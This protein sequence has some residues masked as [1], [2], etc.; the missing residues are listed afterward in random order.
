M[1]RGVLV[2]AVCVLGCSGARERQPAAKS[3]VTS[4]QIAA[5][6][7]A[8][9]PLRRTFDVPGAAVALVDHGVTVFAKGYGLRD[10]EAGNPVTPNTVFRIGSLTKS[11]TSALVATLVDDGALGFDTRATDIDPS[12]KLPTGDLTDNVT[13]L[14]LLGMGTGLSEPSGFWWDYP[15][16]DDLL[17]SIATTMVVGPEG[18]FLY[19]N[20]VYASGGYVALESVASRDDLAS[21]YAS[22]LDERLFQPLGMSPVAL[23][24]DPSTLGDDVALSYEPSLVAGPDAP[25]E[26][27]GFTPLASVAPAGAIATNVTSLARYAALQL[28]HGLAGT[29]RV[30]SAENLEVTHT[31]QTPIPEGKDAPWLSAYA[32]GWIVGNEGGVPLLWHDGGVDAYRATLRLLPDDELALVTLTNGSNGE[33]LGV[34]LEEKLMQLVYGQADL[35]PEHYTSEYAVTREQLAEVA[36]ALALEAP[37]DA[38]AVAPFLGDYGHEISVELDDTTDELFVVA[39]GSRSRVVRADDLFTAGA[40]LLASG[41]FAGN[42]LTFKQVGARTEFTVLDPVSHDPLLILAR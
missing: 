9:D 30:V 22:L 3:G 1:T 41:P 29:K 26:S 2:F 36:Q 12:F 7:A 35:G 15:T 13:V 42:E 37:I 32:A 34:A 4:D 33:L 16:P 27:T 23:T 21:T 5:L 11:F 19:N 18:T 10:L 6:D 31:A 38:D 17:N 14:E 28:A 24:D 39:P 25:P 40:Y 8:V 20:E